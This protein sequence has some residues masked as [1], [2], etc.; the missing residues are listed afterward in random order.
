M[1]R[2]PLIKLWTMLV[3]VID[4]LLIYDACFAYVSVT[5]EMCPNVTVDPNT[6]HGF[7][8]N[9]KDRR[10]KSR[11]VSELLRCVTENHR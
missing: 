11:K 1:I 6:E 8:C 9:Q 5:S 3:D 4:L 7:S 10:F 2:I